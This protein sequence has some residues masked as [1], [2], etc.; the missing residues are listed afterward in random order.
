MR[1]G[2]AQPGE[3]AAAS[4]VNPDIV[5]KWRQRAGINTRET[6]I[7]RVRRLLEWKPKPVPVI[8]DPDAAP[9]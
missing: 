8:D 5:R 2:H 6:R 9:Y 1:S 3:I 7:D 4:G